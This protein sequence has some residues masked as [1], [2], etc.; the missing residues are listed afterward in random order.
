MGHTRGGRRG[1]SHI[2]ADPEQREQRQQREGLGHSGR[3][4]YTCV[5]V[6]VF[7]LLCKISAGVLWFSSW[8]LSVTS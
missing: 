8:W 2:R 7:F 4:A 5:Y 1:A 3:G 6:C